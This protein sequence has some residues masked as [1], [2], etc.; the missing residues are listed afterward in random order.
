MK[1][2][3]S[4]ISCPCTFR[5]RS[6]VFCS[7]WLDHTS[8]LVFTVFQEQ[9][10]NEIKV[11]KDEERDR[12]ERMEIK[13]KEERL[14]GRDWRKYLGRERKEEILNEEGEEEKRDRERENG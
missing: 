2:R 11:R 14:R 13:K 4:K 8:I 12:G 5:F 10:F 6:T 7:A 1:K 9:L 3:R